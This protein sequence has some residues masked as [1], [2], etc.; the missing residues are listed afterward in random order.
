M[1]GGFLPVLF[2]PVSPAPRMGLTTWLVLGKCLLNA[3]VT[4]EDENSPPCVHSTWWRPHCRA[5]Y[6]SGSVTGVPTTPAPEAQSTGFV[7]PEG[8]LMAQHSVWC[9]ECTQ[10]MLMNPG[11]QIL[12]LEPVK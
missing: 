1:R 10:E 11:L 8:S 4:S 7:I 9:A 6:T 2:T 12:L 5:Y 3:P